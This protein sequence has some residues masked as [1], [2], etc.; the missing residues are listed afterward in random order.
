MQAYI[1]LLSYTDAQQVI[2]H[3]THYVFAVGKWF[4]VCINLVMLA[5]CK[6][7]SATG[8]AEVAVSFGR[9]QVM[10]C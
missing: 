8:K 4:K 10:A 3:V 1:P 5:I 6:V 7:V 9:D 2:L